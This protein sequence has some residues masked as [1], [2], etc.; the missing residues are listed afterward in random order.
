M[1]TP[2]YDE[3]RAHYEACLAAHGDSHLGVNWPR[4]EDAEARHRVMADLLAPV[5]GE[6]L[7]VLDF[8]CGL[9]HFHAYLQAAGRTDVDYSGLDLSPR[10]VE[11]ARA[12]LPDVPFV[13]R[14]VLAD[15]APLPCYDYVVAN[16]VFTSKQSL[17][18]A[19]M[20]GF[21]EA[22]LTRLWPAARRGLAFNVMS[23]H[24]D[25]EVPT[26]F[27]LP[28]DDMAR[29]V[30]GALTRHF[31]IRADYGLYDYTVYL[32][33]DPKGAPFPWPSS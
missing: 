24:V 3:L 11:A 6:R 16:G 9:A 12:K 22:L 29:F 13:C 18:Q 26:L 8:G 17:T 27:H 31:T 19:E 23:K 20:T 7:S 21:F 1:T 25:W 30:R 10:F 28:F 15:D 33:R 5:P 14:D 4:A 32:H 2:R